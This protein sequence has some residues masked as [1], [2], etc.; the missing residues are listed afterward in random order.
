MRGDERCPDWRQ[1]ASSPWLLSA[2]HLVAAPSASIWYYATVGLHPLLGLVLV[3]NTRRDRRCA[4]LGAGTSW[5]RPGSACSRRDWGSGWRWPSSAP[6]AS[7]PGS[8]RST[9]RCRRPARCYGASICGARPSGTP[10]WIRAVRIGLDSSPPRPD[11]TA[12]LLRAAR[13]AEWRQ[14]HRIENPVRPP[15]SDGRRG[16]R[17]GEP[18]RAVI[19]DDEHRR[20]HSGRLLP[21]ERDLRPVPCRHLPAV[22]RVG[23]SFL[24]VQQPVVPAV[25]RVHA[26]GGGHRPV[27][28]VRR[29]PRP[30]GVLQRA[31]RSTHRGADRHPGGPGR[32]QLHVVPLHRARRQHHGSGRLHHRVPAVARPSPPASSRCCGTC[33]ISCCGSPPDRIATR[34]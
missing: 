19:G 14:T 12:P 1:P 27:E 21:D 18:V 25:H 5:P 8:C 26:G 13:D 28:V 17:R 29:L 24:V 4:A 9:S 11:S 2:A 31:L 15:A 16:S 33:T 23:P 22:E 32:T 10:G 7:T 34:S 20:H 6:P 30:C 3:G